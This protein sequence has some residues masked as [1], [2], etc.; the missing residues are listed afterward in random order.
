M[1]APVVR[2]TLYKAA[3]S[4]DGMP[5]P[6]RGTIQ[7]TTEIPAVGWHWSYRRFASV[8]EVVEILKREATG[9]HRSH[10]YNGDGVGIWVL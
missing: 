2:K 8:E 5:G 1:S 3:D 7:C 10:S 4:S 9:Q 6:R